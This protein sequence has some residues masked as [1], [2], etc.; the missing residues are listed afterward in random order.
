M[1]IAIGDNGIE[2]E[3]E[4]MIVR[5]SPSDCIVYGIV[6]PRDETNVRRASVTRGSLHVSAASPGWSSVVVSKTQLDLLFY[7]KN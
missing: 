7:L 4:A 2:S 3:S 6:H 5:I 1:K